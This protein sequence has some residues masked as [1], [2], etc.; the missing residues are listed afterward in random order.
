MR[1]S[2]EQ[3]AIVRR[4]EPALSPWQDVE[5]AI[6]RATA[7]RDTVARD[8]QVERVVR[9]SWIATTVDRAINMWF[10]AQA[11]SALLRRLAALLPAS[12]G[13]A[14]ARLRL[15]AIATGVAALTALVVQ[16]FAGRPAPLVWLVPATVTATALIVFLLAAP[17]AAAC[18][19]RH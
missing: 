6:A 12:A 5:R 2:V 3:S 14:A 15:A 10:V 16:P 18:A 19:N 9:A 4:L 8:R 7:P 17:F 11:H 1:Q 13:S